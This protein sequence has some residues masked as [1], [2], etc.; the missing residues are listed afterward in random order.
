MWQD[1]QFT[2]YNL[3]YIN[4]FFSRF[5]IEW[6]SCFQNFV[7]VYT[8]LSLLTTPI[9]SESNQ[10]HESRIINSFEFCFWLSPSWIARLVTCDCEIQFILV[11]SS[12]SWYHFLSNWF[13]SKTTKKLTL[14]Y[15]PTHH[16]DWSLTCWFKAENSC[17]FRAYNMA[18]MYCL[19][20]LSRN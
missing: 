19:N 11:T 9:L 1:I 8:T 7:S 15:Y 3:Q 4:V 2:I 6:F 12:F 20:S 14:N 5:K 17:T 16:C 10:N 13:Q 18:I